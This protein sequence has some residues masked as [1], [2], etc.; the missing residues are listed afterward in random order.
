M[1]GSGQ[2]GMA[3]HRGVYGRELAGFGRADVGKVGL[4][5]QFPQD[6]TLELEA[7]RGLFQCPRCGCLGC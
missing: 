3:A 4:S 1:T 7:M 6:S 2:F 5:D